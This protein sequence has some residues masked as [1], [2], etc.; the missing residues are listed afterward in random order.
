VGECSFTGTVVRALQAEAQR[1]DHLRPYITLFP[2]R[3]HRSPFVP[4]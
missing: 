3:R 2:S 4:N 1:Q